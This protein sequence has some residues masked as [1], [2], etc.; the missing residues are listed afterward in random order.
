MMQVEID[1][2]TL[3]TELRRNPETIMDVLASFAEADERMDDKLLTWIAEA[4]CG[5]TY[6]SRV[7][8]W[9]RRLIA[10]LEGDEA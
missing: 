3:A 7:P 9:L 4:D 6:H 5:S 2:E 8:A 1:I 10:A